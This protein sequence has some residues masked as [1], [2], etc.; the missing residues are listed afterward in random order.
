MIKKRYITRDLN[1][2]L[3]FS[4]L[5]HIA[6]LFFNAFF[7]SF[8]MQIATN[9]IIDVSVYKLFE[10]IATMGGFFLFATIC[11]KYNKVFVFGLSSVP[12]I[13]LLGLILWLGD[14]VALH[15][16]PLGL[17][18]GINSAMYWLPMNSMLVEKV[19]AQSMPRYFGLMTSVEYATKV[20]AP[21]V[22]GIFITIGSYREMSV[23]LL[24]LSVVE[25]FLAMFLTP[26]H[27]RHTKPIDFSG[28]VQCIGRFPLVK[29][30]FWV[31]VLR[32][33]SSGGPLVTVITFYT[34][35]MFHTDLNLG[36]FTTIFS[37]CSI[38]VSMLFSRFATREMFPKILGLQ[39]CFIV[40]G[41][42]V[43]VGYTTP[44]TFLI[45]NFVAATSIAV[46]TQICKVNVYNLSQSKCVSKNH[47]IEY[48]VMRDFALFLGRW[49]SYVLLI[50]IG[51][52]ADESWLRYYL[53][54]I[55]VVMTISGIMSVGVS[56]RIRNR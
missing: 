20:I 56:K 55:T 34:V 36:I 50:Y 51:V 47:Q 43:F 21:V 5:R 19:P 4:G 9:A 13:V 38:I 53:L 37:I 35:Y 40:I 17:L 3:I 18:F 46:M 52:F 48:F 2:L 6:D 45:Y 41:L 1:L 24:I 32:G 11:K 12:K 33:F 39:L 22:L 26:S 7:I 16:M 54:L 27:H 49:A 42:G 8:I 30:I 28:F 44:A 23:V 25:L 29:K 10:F 14:N 15:I 31:E